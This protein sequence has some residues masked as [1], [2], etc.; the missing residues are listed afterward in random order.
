MGNRGRST[1]VL[2]RG[3]VLVGGYVFHCWKVCS[4]HK[5]FFVRPISIFDKFDIYFVMHCF[6][7]FQFRFWSWNWD[8]IITSVVADL[9]S[10]VGV[11]QLTASPSLDLANFSSVNFPICLLL[12]VI[13]D[14][15][16]PPR[17]GFSPKLTPWSSTDATE[18]VSRFLGPLAFLGP[19][20][21]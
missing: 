10:W 7:L 8:V 9:L 21:L 2:N 16:S 19:L 1:L 11:R 17:W 6:S 20:P 5:F 18:L 14:I 4:Q 12:A 15:V 3:L 13:A